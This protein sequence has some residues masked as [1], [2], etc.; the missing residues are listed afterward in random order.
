MSASVNVAGKA[1][2]GH[3][4]RLAAQPGIGIDQRL[5]LVEPRPVAV[6]TRVQGRFVA[7]GRIDVR[8]RGAQMRLQ[9]EVVEPGQEPLVRTLLGAP[10]QERGIGIPL[11]QIPP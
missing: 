6:Q 3:P 5:H 11:L 9:P 1:Q 4:D 10:G 8:E 7:A 2:S